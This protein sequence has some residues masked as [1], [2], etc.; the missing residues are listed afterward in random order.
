M[1]C[2]M[3]SITNTNL[4]SCSEKGKMQISVLKYLVPV[5]STFQRE[6]SNKCVRTPD[7][8]KYL[9]TYLQ[10]WHNVMNLAL[11]QALSGFSSIGHG[12]VVSYTNNETYSFIQCV[13]YHDQQRNQELL[14]MSLYCR[15]VWVMGWLVS[16]FILI[17]LN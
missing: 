15:I 6:I 14:R 5:V 11:K 8:K 4:L 3:D 9:G 17:I 16:L 7:K 12:S 10:R 1:F 2:Q 13:E